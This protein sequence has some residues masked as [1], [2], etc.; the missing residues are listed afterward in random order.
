MADEALDF[1]GFLALFAAASA[2]RR[3]ST[4]V[5]DG[6]T[7]SL[8]APDP[9]DRALFDVAIHADLGGEPVVIAAPLAPVNAAI[10]DLFGRKR[11]PRLSKEDE[12]LLLE[13]ATAPFLEPL[14][15]AFDAPIAF[16]RLD[17]KIA[18]AA[19]SG[20]A[21]DAALQAPD[22]RRTVFCV[23]AAEP[24]LRRILAVWQATEPGAAAGEPRDVDVAM[25][26]ELGTAI[27]NTERFET[28]EIGDVIVF[29]SSPLQTG[30][31]LL[32]LG[33]RLSAEVD[34]SGAGPRLVGGFTPLSATPR[35][36]RDRGGGGRARPSY[37]ATETQVVAEWARA[38]APLSALA[39]MQRDQALELPSPHDGV[40][41]LR[42]ADADLDA[43]FAEGRLVRVGDHVGVRIGHVDEAARNAAAAARAM[44]ASPDAQ[45]LGMIGSWGQ[46]DG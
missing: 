6:E 19:L 39:E 10:G 24:V 29:E 45:A 34:F 21:I 27:V 42:A 43:A 40:V 38:L 36:W 30:K 41:S 33:D 15:H 16:T 37:P 9:S 8:S 5:L 2:P 35:A 3:L 13:A 18:R 12:A 1:A 17:R 28:L 11:P 7:L 44:L 26:V 31:G 46:L 20:P 25:T 4:P 23:M 14:E 32:L 22:G